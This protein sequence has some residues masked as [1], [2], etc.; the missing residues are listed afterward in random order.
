M[1]RRFA[2][3]HE[4]EADHRIATELADRV[5]IEAIDWLD[6]DGIDDQRE[7]V[8]EETGG[9]RLTWKAIKK[10]APEIGIR[11]HGHFE[12]KPGEP[13]AVASRRAILYLRHVI[14]DLSA[15]VLVRDQDDQPE[16]RGG[17]EQARRGDH[18]GVAILVGL[19]VVEREC[20]V[21]CGF[22][23][24][25]EAETALLDEERRNLGFDPRE[26][27]HRLTACKDDRALRSPKRVL[28]ALTREDRDRERPCW[29]D[30]QLE[31]LRRRGSGNGLAE[32]L[33]EVRERLA[34]L[35]GHVAGGKRASE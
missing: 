5:M 35:I 14:P 9:R 2:V 16:R 4:A 15:I 26:Q 30:T 3:V 33:G 17:I 7:W 28:R 24:V 11:V 29:A 10:L 1:R 6:A 20:W 12:G 34:Y 19:A 32:Y 27:S 31:V 18:G 8:T 23:P 25:D 22:D 13:D 21:L